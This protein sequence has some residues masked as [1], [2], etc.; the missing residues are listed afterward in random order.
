MDCGASFHMMSQDEVTSGEKDT[1]R[2]SREPTVITN[3]NGQ[4]EKTEEATVYVNDLD[5]F[6]IMMLLEDSPAVPSLGLPCGE[7]CHYGKRESLHRC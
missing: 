1:I 5:V 7:I 4:V 2:R 6:D 3:A